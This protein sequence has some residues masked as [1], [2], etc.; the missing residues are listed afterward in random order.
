MRG[1]SFD[2]GSLITLW[3]SLPLEVLV[4]IFR[5]TWENVNIYLDISGIAGCEGESLTI[6]FLSPIHRIELM[7]IFGIRRIFFSYGILSGN[8]LAC[9][10]FSRENL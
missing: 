7:A 3:N 5:S 4:E 2:L 10:R 8:N 9:S 1:A 6:M